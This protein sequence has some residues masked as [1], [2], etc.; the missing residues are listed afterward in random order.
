MPESGQL[1]TLKKPEGAL[2]LELLQKAVGIQVLD[3]S[4][5]R[6]SPSG[7]EV[8]MLDLLICLKK[9]DSLSPDS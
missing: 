8:I 7:T 1:R 5:F 4:Q 9:P 6:E 3:L 2:A